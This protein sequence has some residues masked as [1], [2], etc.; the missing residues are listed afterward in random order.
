MQKL[1]NVL[2][3]VLECGDINIEERFKQEQAKK[4]KVVPIRRL[5]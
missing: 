4:E 1:E 5:G 3:D 2:N